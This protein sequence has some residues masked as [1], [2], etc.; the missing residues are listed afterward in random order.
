VDLTALHFKGPAEVRF[1]NYIL[2]KRSIIWEEFIVDACSRL[3]DDP[4]RKVVEDFNRLQQ[5][6]TLEEYLTI[7]E[8]LKAL[9]LVTNPTML[10]SYFLESFIGGLKP[11]I[12]SFV[13]AFNPQT[14]YAAMK[15]ARHQEETIHSWKISPD[16]GYN[17]KPLVPT[18]LLANKPNAG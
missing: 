11:I 15:I 3:R 7:F 2:G 4:G 1:N 12:K 5:L 18:L 6:G 17:P 9:M 8:E 10:A 13:R 16:S 14:L